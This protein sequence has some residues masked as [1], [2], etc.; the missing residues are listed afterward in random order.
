MKEDQSMIN[1]HNDWADSDGYASESYIENGGFKKCTEEIVKKIGS[2]KC[3][4]I[5]DDVCDFG[6]EAEMAGFF[7]GLRRGILFMAGILKGGER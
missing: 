2:E 4:S 6:C 7:E 3:K 1:F 5:S